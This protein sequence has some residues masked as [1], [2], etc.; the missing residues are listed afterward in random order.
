ML[1]TIKSAVKAV[2]LY[3]TIKSKKTDYELYKDAL[4][5]EESCRTKLLEASTAPHR[6]D[7]LVALH[8]GMLRDAAAIRIAFRDD[9][10]AAIDRRGDGGPSDNP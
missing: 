7:E 5:R 10:G 2:E 8:R 1:T 6:T 9:L 4:S 3:L